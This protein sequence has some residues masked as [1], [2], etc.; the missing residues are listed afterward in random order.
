MFTGVA[1]GWDKGRHMS[2]APPLPPLR[3]DAKLTLTGKILD[4]PFA[5]VTQV[6]CAERLVPEVGAL[7]NR[8]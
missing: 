1:R 5:I 2:R 4:Q 6:H 7:E 3:R 8:F